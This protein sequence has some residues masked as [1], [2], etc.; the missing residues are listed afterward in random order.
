[1]LNSHSCLSIK[2]NYW[3][4]PFRRVQSRICRFAAGGTTPPGQH[5]RGFGRCSA[6]SYHAAHPYAVDKTE[7]TD[8]DNNTTR[9]YYNYDAMGNQ[10]SGAG[11]SLDYTPFNKIKSIYR[12]TAAQVHFTYGPARSRLTRTDITRTGNGR[13]TTTT[14]YLGNVEHVIAEDGSSTWK[15]YLA[16]GAVLITQDHDTR[17]T[18]T[19]ETT[20]YLLKDHLGS[21]TA[22]LNQ[23]GRLDQS[24][25]YDAWGQRRTPGT[26]AILAL[27][28][29]RSTLHSRTTP[30]GYTGHEMLDAYGI[31]HM[32][33]RIYDPRLGRFLQADP[34]VQFPHYSQSWNTYSYVLNNPLTY[35]NPSGY[36]IGKLFKKVFKGLNK[37][38]GDFAPFLGIALL[39]IPVVREWVISSWGSAF[40]FGFW[41]GGIAS[42]SYKGALFGGISAAAFYGI[43]S[44]FAAEAGFFQQGGF[45]HVLTHGLAGGILAELQGGQFGHGFLAA[46]IS[47]AV[48][49]RFS[50]ADGSAPAVMGRTAIAATVGGTISRITGGKF[51]NGALTSA[52]AQLF[53][54][55]TRARNIQNGVDYSDC[56]GG[57]ACVVKNE[58]VRTEAETLNA[59]LQEHTGG[60]VSV[61]GGDRY[62]DSERDG[63]ISH[64]TGEFVDD[65]IGFHNDQMPYNNR[66][67]DIRFAE[68]GLTR[69]QVISFIHAHTD[70]KVLHS[71]TYPS[72]V[73]NRGH[74]HIT[75]NAD[76]CINQ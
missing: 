45:G 11:R 32:N 61:S 1:M 54:A 38:F 74:I 52:M 73:S 31:I 75:C 3:H 58:G 20:H 57:N 68:T 6:Y 17:D 59:A 8:Q 18:R 39:A 37:V 64:S 7:I 66:A 47:K 71:K 30:R 13:T 15:R 56:G 21:L 33:G 50:Y 48:M 46:G 2:R 34:I 12:G 23:Y 24:F 16:N 65:S 40:T 67:L 43:G 60:R 49:G 62:Y 42:G 36:F 72:G 4:N 53:N 28:T 25:S 9:T 44:Q 69:N 19:A 22:L 35:T 76:E 14:V 55:E 10:V 27:L 5:R 51:A 63:S 29:L 70:F 41:T 26:A